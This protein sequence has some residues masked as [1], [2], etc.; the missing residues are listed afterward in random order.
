MVKLPRVLHC[1][2]F[3][4]LYTCLVCFAGLA[5]TR[6]STASPNPVFPGRLV[7]VDGHRM[8]IYCEGRGLPSIIFDSGTGGFSLEWT[9]VQKV[10]SR[11]TRVCSYDRAGYG[12][13]E[14]GPLPRTSDRIT[15][16]LHT[17]LGKAGVI[18]P[19][20]L[21]GHS[22]GGYTA[23]LFAKNYPEETA[24]LVLIDSSHPEQIVRMPAREKSQPRP[25]M[26]KARSYTV[27]RHIPH[28]NY[29]DEMTI[30]AN[31][32]MGSWSHTMTWREEMT[33]FSLSAKQVLLSK[34]MP[35]VPVVVL[36]R[37]IRVWP[38]NDY[39]NEMERVW[40]ELQDELSQLSDNSVHLIAERSGHM[41]HLD[42]PG[43]VINAIQTLLDSNF[44]DK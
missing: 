5:S 27:T 31:R 28:P 13:S 8:H 42:Q 2:R 16:E 19:Y 10:L 17:L 14:M 41:I 15:R 21:A 40:M 18:G 30:V 35:A 11:K 22:F 9:E 32:I 25:R 33:G 20:I 7:D 39:G 12:W 6:A 3:L 38:N 29:P 36:T 1:V 24:G 34:P 26:P 44:P 43:I 23:Q 37:G 4:L